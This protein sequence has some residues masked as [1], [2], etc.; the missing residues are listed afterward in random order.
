MINLRKLP[1]LVAGD[2]PYFDYLK[3]LLEDQGEL[4]EVLDEEINILN[5]YQN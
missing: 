3:D 1:N 2:I 5:L 4:N